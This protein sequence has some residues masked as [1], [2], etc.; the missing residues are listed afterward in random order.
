MYVIV[1]IAYML[2]TFH[3]LTPVVM[4]PELMHDLGMDAAQFGLLGMGFLW[5]YALSQAP[6]GIM[7]DRIGPRIGLL[8]ILILAATACLLFST[9]QSFPAAL[10]AR[11]LTGIA[12]SGF[13]VGGAKVISAW[14]SPREYTAMYPIFMGL[15]A[16]GGVL[17]ATPLQFMM[18]SF[19]WRQAIVIIGSFSLA[20]AVLSAWRLR[21]NP[22]DLALPAPHE[23]LKERAPQKPNFQ[24]GEAAA[25]PPAGLKA[26]KT[27]LSMPII[28]VCCLLGLGMNSS[29]Q[30]LQALW[31]GVYLADVYALEKLTISNI[32]MA[33]SIGFVLGAIGAVWFLK[34]MNAIRTLFFGAGGFLCAWIYMT[35]KAASM[36]V[37]ELMVINLLL[38]FTQLLA[39]TATFALIKESV[40]G[41]WLGTAIGCVNAFFWI[42]GGGLFQQIWGLI[43]NTVSKGV[44]PYPVEAF[45]TVFWVQLIVLLAT[46]AYALIVYRKIS[47]APC[48]AL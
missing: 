27:V 34:K 41:A 47:K 19:G 48:S 39:M 32:L 18:T 20:L 33:S 3:R 42:F 28:W 22:A 25:T 4:G 31:N 17:A 24:P 36:S 7:M 43:I 37:P 23:L 11:T 26:I 12:V 5:A 6:A 45:L 44:R 9:A 10:A 38:G 46:L 30:S 29:G 15:G 14:Y 1:V 40:P 13:L 35:V 2:A 21:N 8:V 16:L